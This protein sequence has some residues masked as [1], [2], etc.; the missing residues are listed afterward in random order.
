MDVSALADVVDGN[1]P[2]IVCAQAGEVNTGF[3]DLAAIASSSPA[4]GPRRRRVRALGGGSRP[5]TPPHGY[6]RADSWATDAHKWLNVPY[7]CGIASRT[8]TTTGGDGVRRRTS[9][10]ARRDPRPDGYARHSRG[11]AP[12]V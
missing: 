5:S 6:E 1:G 2:T 4:A 7:D 11:A 10:A 9:R 8:P 12:P 3:D